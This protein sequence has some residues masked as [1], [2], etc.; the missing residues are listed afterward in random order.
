VSSGTSAPTES[1]EPAEPYVYVF[2]AGSDDDGSDDDLDAERRDAI[3]E[4]LALLGIPISPDDV[5]DPDI[6]D[7]D[8]QET[9]KLSNA[10]AALI[11]WSRNADGELTT[12]AANIISDRAVVAELDHVAQRFNRLPRSLDRHYRLGPGPRTV[13]MADW[14]GDPQ[15]PLLLHLA[16]ELRAVM[17]KSVSRAGGLSTNAHQV[18]ARSSGRLRG[19][20]DVP[21]MPHDVPP[22]PTDVLLEALNYSPSHGGVGTELLLVLSQRQGVHP[23]ELLD[24]VFLGRREEPDSRSIT[25]GPPLDALLDLAERCAVQVSGHAEIHLRHLLAAAVLSDSPSVD[26]DALARLGTSAAELP[27]TLLGVLRVARIGDSIEAWERL[28]AV[29][30]AGGFDR[31]LVD[32]ATAISRDGDDLGYGVWAAMF[33]SVIADKTTRMPVSIGLFG[34][35]GSGKSTFMGLLRGEIAELCGRPGYVRDVVPIVFN[36]WHYADANLWASLGDEIFRALADALKPSDEREQSVQ[37]QEAALLREITEQRSLAE[38]ARARREQAERVA[39]AA[40]ERLATQQREAR[41]DRQVSARD[42]VSALVDSSEARSA[43]QQEADRAWQLLGISDDVERGEMLAGQLD[44]ISQDGRALRSLLG[45]R[46]T[47]GLAG[48]SLAGLLLTLAAHVF[49][50]E[51]GAW[52]RGV[53]TWLRHYG[54]FTTLAGVLASATVLAGRFRTG[55]AALR[56]AAALAAG[57]ADKKAN[58][59]VAAARDRLRAAQTRERATDAEA[60]RVSANLAGLEGQLAGLAPGRRMY[61]FL[62][63]RA[64]SGDYAGQLGLVSIIRK[65]LEHLV[66]VL[67]EHHG[68]LDRRAGAT[69]EGDQPTA[70]E[71]RRIDRIVLY[72]D[73]LDRCP[74]RQVVEVLQAVHLLLALDLFVVVVGVDPRWLVRALCE[75]YPGILTD[76]AARSATESAQGFAGKDA[77]GGDVGEAVP[78]DYLQKIFNIPFALPAFRG[79]QLEQLVRRLANNPAA[80]VTD[81]GGVLR[82]GVSRFGDPRGATPASTLTGTTADSGSRASTP[83][84][85][86]A[87]PGT[88]TARRNTTTGDAA[89]AISAEPGSQV[90]AIQAASPLAAGSRTG[91]TRSAASAAAAPQRLNEEELRFL[92]GLGPF[93][94][95]PRDAKRLFNVYRLLRS[96]RDLSP[97]SAFLGGDYQAVA[98]LLAMLNQDSHVFGRATDALSRPES[99]VTGGLTQ[100]TVGAE[101]WAGFAAGLIPEPETSPDGV[102]RPD[103]AWRNRIVGEIPAAD[104]AAWSRMAD[105]VRDTSNLVTLPDLTAFRV[106]TP[107]V[108][109]FSYLLLTSTR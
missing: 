44:G 32:P 92:G 4:N 71:P 10:A 82:G 2:F 9:A 7:F 83:D 43:A 30:L 57:K 62:A 108:R 105:A 63:E 14:T 96:T 75:Q 15:D 81:Q 68:R 76:N 34:Q 106:W 99:G 66:K 25:A 40:A 50:D 88:D 59:E 98:M 61:T 47:W 103:S 101:N 36:A 18:L 39:K 5:F 95:T 17:D 33:A 93:I 24:Q 107:H 97:A 89:P 84:D 64:A 90:A 55:L 54:G 74:P 6:T 87:D 73:D 51:W 91:G 94:R 52:L 41:G 79:D 16:D 49:A 46:M 19:R 26:G 85:P 72:I 65:D 38:D 11:F 100:A 23:G 42:L 77:A 45:W 109:R 58:T 102:T 48:V 28:L 35:W 13:D 8:D 56:S 78:S 1:G 37:E 67:H 20:S 27:G 29:S 22:S 69:S 80:T 86:D 3:V 21:P 70:P 12:V 53:G 60:E 31:D 104:L